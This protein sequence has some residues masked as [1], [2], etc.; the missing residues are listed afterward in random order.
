MTAGVLGAAAEH[1]AGL[2]EAVQR[3]VYF[4][5]AS[6]ARLS[7]PLTGERLAENPKD[8]ALFE[9][10]AAVNERFAK[11]QD[12]LG[13]AMRHA[14]MLAGEPTDT[15]LRTLVFFEK[16]G[17]LDAV[18][19]WQLC[20]TTRN[21]AAHEYDIDYDRIA[22][23]FNALDELLPGLYGTAARFV[24]Y[25]ESSLGIRPQ[26]GAFAPEFAAL[27]GRAGDSSVAQR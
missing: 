27:T 26:P 10:L 4:L 11:L 7:W 8:V 22:A 20:R 1:L 17:V 12:T 2:L 15:F 9:A 23:H 5:D 13:A 6:R 25:C 21:L 24:G 19:Q 3:C 14:A 16:V 18:A